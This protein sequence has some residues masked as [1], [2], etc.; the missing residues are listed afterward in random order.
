M[1]HSM[2]GS[3]SEILTWTHPPPPPPP[4]GQSPCYIANRVG[5][6][7]STFDQRWVKY[8]QSKLFGQ[9]DP[10]MGKT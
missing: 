4:P 9:F 3:Q 10:M 5:Q 6:N 1:C 2:G 8:Q 7:L